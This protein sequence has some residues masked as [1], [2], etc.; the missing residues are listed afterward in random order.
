MQLDSFLPYETTLKLIDN[1]NDIDI[2]SPFVFIKHQTISEEIREQYGELTDDGYYELTVDGGGDLPFD[3]VYV[4]EIALSH[5]S[6]MYR[7]GESKL[8]N[9]YIYDDIIDWLK[10]KYNYDLYTVPTKKGYKWIISK[11]NSDVVESNESSVIYPERYEALHNAVI[12][13]IENKLI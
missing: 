3:E 2:N 12:Y 5:I 4:D 8:A 1:V 10:N 13:L 6:D 7:F 11:F 9:G